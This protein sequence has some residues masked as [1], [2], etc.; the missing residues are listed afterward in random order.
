MTSEGEGTMYTLIGLGKRG[1]LFA[2]EGDGLR[3]VADR[4][5][6]LVAS[7]KDG[8]SLTRR[9]EQRCGEGHEDEKGGAGKM[10][11]QRQGG[12]ERQTQVDHLRVAL[13]LYLDQSSLMQTM[14]LPCCSTA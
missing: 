12:Q 3:V 5:S 6:C 4:T 14:S 10:E 2:K 8:R 11:Q 9:W 7:G 13:L 1:F